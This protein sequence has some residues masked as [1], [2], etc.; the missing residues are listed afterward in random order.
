MSGQDITWAGF[1][2]RKPWLAAEGGHRDRERREIKRDTAT[3][4]RER[5]KREEDRDRIM[6]VCFFHIHT[7]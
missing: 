1:C 2:Y 3:R 7:Q 5:Q 4:E 6:Y